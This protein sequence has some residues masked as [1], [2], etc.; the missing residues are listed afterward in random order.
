MFQCGR[1]WTVLANQYRRIYGKAIRNT[2]LCL[3]YCIV[4][5]A[6]C[7]SP[8]NN[9]TVEATSGASILSTCA[10]SISVSDG[11]LPAPS[12]STARIRAHWVANELP[13]AFTWRRKKYTPKFYTA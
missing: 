13:S 11:G 8:E 6:P 12:A 4:V 5:A 9:F 3:I 1:T 7:D 10:A 2:P